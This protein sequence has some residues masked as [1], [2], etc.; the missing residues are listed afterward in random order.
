[1][2]DRVQREKA[3]YNDGGVF[4]ASLR[5]QSRFWHVF[6][7]PNTQRLERYV[8]ECI[9]R[10]AAGSVVLDYGCLYGDLY[11]RLEAYGPKR[12]IGIDISE[13]AIQRATA[14]YGAKAEYL[15]MDAHRTSFP[16]A[17]FDLVVGRAILHH[18]DWETAIRELHRIL[19]PGGVAVFVEPLG[20]N[21]AARFIRWSTPKARTLDETPVTRRQIRIADQI[22]GGA[23]HRFANLISV[24]VAMGTSRLSKNPNN[25]LLRGCDRV[26]ELLSR[27]ALRYWMR[28]VALVWQRS[29]AQGG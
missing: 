4:D 12:V 6:Q 17:F 19:R 13:N 2:T 27:S 20:D 23:R 28:T 29:A 21:P 11:P 10:R 26:D 5:L 15:V 22:M 8:H 16:D 24:P 3:A 18:L 7:C 9:S 14:R 25:A 1:M